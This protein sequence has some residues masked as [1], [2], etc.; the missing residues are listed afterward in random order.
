MIITANQ[1]TGSALCSLT[2]KAVEYEYEREYYLPGRAGDPA[3]VMSRA[4][5]LSSSSACPR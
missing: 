3:L 2:G 5:R 4:P 1:L